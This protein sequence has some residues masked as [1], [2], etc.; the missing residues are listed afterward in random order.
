MKR[1]Y[2]HLAKLLRQAVQVFPKRF[3]IIEENPSETYVIL[4]TAK[5]KRR[6]TFCL[7]RLDDPMEMDL[8]D[9][10]ALCAGVGMLF[11]ARYYGA[12]G[13]ASRC[14]YI[15]G[16][17]QVGSSVT[18]STKERASVEGTILCFERSFAD[19]REEKQV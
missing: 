8:N 2:K 15:G 10:D 16:L 19:A 9:M 14:F 3:Q 12:L 18:C 6:N 13:W 5:H 1:E 17:V 4:C 11:D 7:Q